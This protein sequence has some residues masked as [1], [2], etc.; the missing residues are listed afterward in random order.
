MAVTG[1]RR[2]VRRRGRCRERRDRDGSRRRARAT[3]GDRRDAEVIRRAVEQPGL[4]R[5]GNRGT[6]VRRGHRPRRG[7]DGALDEVADHGQATGVRR[8]QPGENRLCVGGETGEVH[9]RGRRRTR[10]GRGDVGRR[11]TPCRGDRT[12]A[13][14]DGHTVVEAVQRVGRRGR[15]GVR[16]GVR[17]RGA[18]VDRLLDAVTRDRITT[19][20]GRSDPTQLR[21]AARGGRHK[22]RRCACCPVG[23]AGDDVTGGT[24]TRRGECGHPESVQLAG[25]EIQ[26]GEGRRR[27][28]RVR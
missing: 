9:R 24:R 3:G 20:R 19:G 28:V 26:N 10:D 21:L 4:H 2:E 14:E 18:T 17:P 11:T 15:P 23:R 6:G 8:G 12:D 22:V 13:E 27:R 7:V 1:G 5:R 25:D 16:D